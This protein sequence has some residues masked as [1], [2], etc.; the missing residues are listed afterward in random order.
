MSLLL[1]LPDC[2][3]LQEKQADKAKAAEPKPLTETQ[4]VWHSM[5][6]EREQQERAQHTRQELP[7]QQQAII[8]VASTPV[9]TVT[10][11][12]RMSSLSNLPLPWATN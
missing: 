11:K 4:R 10:W 2:C 12:I 1:L 3:R 5:R 6:E 8:Q 9:F 7:A